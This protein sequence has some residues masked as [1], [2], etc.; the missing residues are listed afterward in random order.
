ML[1]RQLEAKVVKHCHDLNLL[2]YKFSSPAHRG[3]PDRLILG[4]GRAMFLELKTL[5]KRPTELQ[6]REI[7][8]IRSR[9]IHVNWVDNYETAVQIIDDFFL[10]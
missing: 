1:E 6:I 5:G 9:G 10:V 7:D 3:V 2:C 8:R 4:R